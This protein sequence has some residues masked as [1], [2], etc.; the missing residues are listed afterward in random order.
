MELTCRH[1]I[2]ACT[3]LLAAPDVGCGG[4]VAQAWWEAPCADTESLGM[5]WSMKSLVFPWI[6]N[7][8]DIHTKTQSCDVTFINSS[9]TKL[10]DAN[11]IWLWLAICETIV[12]S[13]TRSIASCFLNLLEKVLRIFLKNFLNVLTFSSSLNASLR[14][15]I[16]YAIETKRCR[17]R[18]FPILFALIDQTG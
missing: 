5:G 17:Q 1:Y 15:A 10:Y 6:V 7:I 4:P 16:N 12:K 3:L 13:V 9:V 14:S 8:Y 2:T 18:R 11:N